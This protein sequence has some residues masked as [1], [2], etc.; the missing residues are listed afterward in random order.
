MKHFIYYLFFAL[1]VLVN[2]NV[3]KAETKV[4]KVAILDPATPG[5]NDPAL[6]MGV[7]ELISNCFVNYGQE[8]SI[9]ERS[10]LD[11]VMQEARF[12]NTDAVDESQATELGRL[13][14]ADR[15]VLSVIS[16]MGTRSLISVKMINVET[17]SVVKQQSKIV[18]TDLLL[19]VI[20]PV[21]MVLLGKENTSTNIE[22][23]LVAKNNTTTHK[24][25]KTIVVTEG[26]TD[27]FADEIGEPGEIPSIKCKVPS[28]LKDFRSEMLIPLLDAGIIN[29][30]YDWSELRIFDM[31]I[32]T[33]LQE[34]YENDQAKIANEQLQIDNH[35]RSSISPFIDKAN[36]KL[37]DVQL[38]SINDKSPIRLIIKMRDSYNLSFVIDYIFVNVETN[39]VLSGV[40]IEKKAFPGRLILPSAPQVLAA[41]KKKNITTSI[42]LFSFMSTIMDKMGGEF[43]KKLNNALK[44]AKKKR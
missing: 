27:P 2:G 34:L 22:T 19:D 40:R 31:P 21:T 37:K 11:K 29:V 41:L 44:D 23:P 42:H 4:L 35:I 33:F 16:K 17:A 43:G 38:S 10:Q 32:N 7:R 12:S 28:Q 24:N 1:V 9:V 30:V 20:E 36:E 6:Q 25:N 14:G 18:E 15:V 26:T 5:N 8:Y 13:A 39:E 3:V